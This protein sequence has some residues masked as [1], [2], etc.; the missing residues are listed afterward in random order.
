[1]KK[2]NIILRQEQ[3][4]YWNYHQVKSGKY[5]YLMGKE[6]F[7]SYQSRILE[8]AKFTYSPLGKAFEEQI[9]TI[10]E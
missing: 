7:S 10:E 8:K 9:K 3:Q 5:G 2:Y 1:M 4:K 6:I